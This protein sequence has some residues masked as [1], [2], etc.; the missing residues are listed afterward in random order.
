MPPLVSPTR[1]YR[2]C[3]IDS[4]FGRG[5]SQ[6]CLQRT[7]YSVVRPR[8]DKR[9]TILVLC[10]HA[11]VKVREQEAKEGNEK[12]KEKSTM[13]PHTRWECKSEDIR[14]ASF[15]IT[16]CAD[17]K[18][19]K[20]KTCVRITSSSTTFRLNL[21]TRAVILQLA[22]RSKGGG[23]FAAAGGGGAPCNFLD[24]LR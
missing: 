21:C 2:G 20:G 6:C 19:K 24:R 13:C 5:Q 18:P 23:W 1:G 11:T 22:I 15:C 12:E 16:T 14:E 8:D 4:P 3:G 17:F 9:K 7:Y 10:G